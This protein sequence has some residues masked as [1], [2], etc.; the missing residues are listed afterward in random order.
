[1]EEQPAQRE[2]VA[3]LVQGA[4]RGLGLALT[5]RLLESGRFRQ[6]VA[7]S[8]DPA[9]SPGL[10]ELQEQWGV[11]L[12]TEAL[13]LADEQSVAGLG[14]R[15]RDSLAP[16]G[17]V[18]NVSGLLHGGGQWP[19]KRLEDVQ[20]A[21]LARSFAVNAVGPL[22][23]AR[24]LW[25]LLA[26]APRAV[27]ANVSARVGS[28]GDNRL[29]GWYG[30]RASKAAQNQLTRTLAIELGRRAPR[31]ICVALHPGTTDTGLSRPFQSR[32]PQ[33]RLFSP[34][35]AAARMLAVIDALGPEDSGGFFAWD[36]QSIPW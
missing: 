8:R 14:T 7:T 17:L 5:R 21:A 16:L 6:V 27:L 34:D 35:Y 2:D 11:R 12:R 29:G 23:V 13:E 32:V 33:D 24:E 20:A 26:R 1:M 19:E 25:P 22:L 10:R 36:G 3:A 18:L 15:L 4:G 28:I 30:Y 9:A 31:V